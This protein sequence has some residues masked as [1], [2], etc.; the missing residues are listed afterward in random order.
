M[1]PENLKCPDCGGPMVRRTAKADGRK[2]WGC[3]TFPAC[4]GT[5]D[6]DGESK[7]DRARWKMNETDADGCCARCGMRHP[8]GRCLETE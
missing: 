4:R 1:K 5:R 2:F 8:S 3:Q 7:A 6:T